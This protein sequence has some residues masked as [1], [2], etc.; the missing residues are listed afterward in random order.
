MK[1]KLFVCFICI[2]LSSEIFSTE[3]MN[4]R[5]LL[6]AESFGFGPSA[7]IAEIFPYLESSLP[8]M[9]YIGTGHSLDLQR[10]LPYEKIFDYSA[11]SELQQKEKFTA[12]AKDHDVFITA[13]DFKAA[14]WAKDLGLTLIIYDP[15]TWYWKEIPDVVKSADLYI[16]Q[17][18]FGV[19]ER[20][21]KDQDLF[22]DYVIVPAI[23][24]ETDFTIKQGNQQN[25]LV[26]MGGLCNPYIS[27]NHLEDFAKTIFGCI[28][29]S[30][31]PMH[32]T[33]TYISSQLIA[34]SVKT[35]CPAKTLQPDQVQR[36]LK[37]SKLAIMTSGLG[38]IYEASSMSKKVIWLPPANDSQGQQIQLLQIHDMVDYRIDW[39]DIF[40]DEDPINYFD[41][42]EI[43]MKQIAI[44]MKRLSF[45]SDA[46][47]RFTQLLHENYEK[48]QS[49]ALPKLSK[50]AYK[51]KINGANIAAEAILKVLNYD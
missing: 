14:R 28:N 50:L 45:E 5:I 33:T 19:Q 43:V 22:K 10:K 32:D 38:N 25:L 46:K 37:K 8:H 31:A 11:D 36:C 49:K 12:I 23:I 41:S 17:D 24:S 35:I 20:L 6:N 51:F 30:L 4:K 27:Q 16:T 39:S 15:L 47:R 13:S 1:N 9:S 7:A 29:N 44:Y 3:F 48:A 2:F 34:D 42:Q 26:N 18:F 21:Q 40:I